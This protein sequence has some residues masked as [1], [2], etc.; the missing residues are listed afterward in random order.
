M[1]E[2]ENLAE[3]VGGHQKRVRESGETLLMKPCGE[4]S[5]ARFER[6]RQT[7]Y[8]DLIRWLHFFGSYDEP[9][10]AHQ[11]IPRSLSVPSKLFSRLGYDS[12]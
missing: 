3:S 10:S 11:P 9:L 12:V 4:A 8:S 1:A 7:G 2:F 5:Y 6:S